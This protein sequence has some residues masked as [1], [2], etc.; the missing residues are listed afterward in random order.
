MAIILGLKRMDQGVVLF[1]RG[2]LL[3]F[4]TIIDIQYGRTLGTMQH[5]V[6]N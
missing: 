6:Y 3:F 1:S 2:R 4:H 5:I